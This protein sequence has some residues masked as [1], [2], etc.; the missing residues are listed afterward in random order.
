MD[1]RRLAMSDSAHSLGAPARHAV[2]EDA[3]GMSVPTLSKHSIAYIVDN[4]AVALSTPRNSPQIAQ[5]L[6]LRGILTAEAPVA[7]VPRTAASGIVCANCGTDHTPLWRRNNGGEPVCNACGQ[8]YKYNGVDRPDHMR[9][10][11][12]VRR[13]RQKTTAKSSQNLAPPG[14]GN[15]RPKGQIQKAGKGKAKRS[16]DGAT[17]RIAMGLKLDTTTAAKPAPAGLQS[18]TSKPAEDERDHR[19]IMPLDTLAIVMLATGT[20]LPAAWHDP[21]SRLYTLAIAATATLAVEKR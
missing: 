4:V 21:G 20:R 16:A 19:P 3:A 18:S 5:T 12:V 17:S 11:A 10:K 2:I 8:Y 13:N 14:S 9:N 7:S 6:G 15:A 1:S